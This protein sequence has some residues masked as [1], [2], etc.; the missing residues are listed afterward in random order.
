MQLEKNWMRGHSLKRSNLKLFGIVGIIILLSQLF[1]DS[2]TYNHFLNQYINQYINDLIVW[3]PAGSI[4]YIL[5]NGILFGILLMGVSIIFIF[6]SNLSKVVIYGKRGLIVTFTA[7][8]IPI[9]LL[10][11]ISLSY[12]PL[13]SYLLNDLI[14]MFFSP[15]IFLIEFILLISLSRRKNYNQEAQIRKTILDLGTNYEFLKLKEIAKNINVDKDSII[16]VVN[17]MIRKKEIYAEY[18]NISR[19]FVFNR[20]VNIEEI[21]RLME[22]YYRWE[23]QTIG[24]I[25]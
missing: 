14:L 21:D 18:F 1:F 2:F 5:W 11:W 22:L 16:K 24:K 23:E 13:I 15:L 10:A 12:S 4:S 25:I 9:C 8:L 19:K 17:E 6:Y 20:R 3:W 7:L